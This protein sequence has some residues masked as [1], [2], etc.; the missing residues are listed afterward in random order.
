MTIIYR[1]SYNIHSN[2]DTEAHYKSGR[3]KNV[4]TSC[5]I[6]HAEKTLLETLFKS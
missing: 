6:G 5:P 3:V 1:D 4:F 2:F